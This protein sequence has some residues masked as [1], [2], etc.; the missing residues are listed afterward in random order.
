MPRKL[1]EAAWLCSRCWPRSLLGVFSHAAGGGGVFEPGAAATDVN[2]PFPCDVDIHEMKSTHM[3]SPVSVSTLN[4]FAAALLG[5]AVS[6]LAAQSQLV[7][8][9]AIAVA[10]E[11]PTSPASSGTREG[12]VSAGIS[13]TTLQ[14]ANTAPPTDAAASAVPAAK[15]EVNTGQDP[16]KPIARL[17]LRLK[18]QDLPGGNSSVVPTLRLDVPL[19]LGESGWTLGTRFDLPFVI[20]DVPSPDN[21]GGDWHG[22]VGDALSQ[23]LLITPPQGRW[24]FGFGTQ[25]IFPTASQ[26]QMGTGKWQLAPIIAGVYALPEISK[27]SFVGLL[28]K[29]QFSVAGADGRKDINDLVIQSLFN[30][31]LPDRW[32]LTFAPEMRFDLEDDGA[33]FIP[34]DLVVGKMITP[35]TVISVEFKAPLLDDYRQYDFEVE[36]RVGFFF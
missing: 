36:F 16:T 25:V 18:Y 2:P 33:A 23:F 4:L 26:D 17:D 1:F 8:L 14:P 35:K 10:S 12:A 6:S 19:E 3:T 21:P 22:G 29:D 13:Q 5:S 30:I 27:G 34:F 7:P 31:N 32:F 9:G 11:S 15:S 20:N 28:I 24:Q